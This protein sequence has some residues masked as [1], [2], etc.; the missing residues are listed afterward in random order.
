MDFLQQ[1]EQT[2]FLAWV[3]GGNSIWGY[4]TIL[5]LHT[6]GLATVAGVNAGIDLR[7]LG[8]APKIPLAPM[9][10]LFPLIWTAFAVTAVSGTILLL[11]D[12]TTKLANPV[13]YI[14]L[15]FI[16]LALVNLQLI[17]TR[18]FGDPLVDTRPVTS[19]AR[20]L[21]LTSLVLWMAATTAGR[22]M[23]YI[24]PVKGL[25]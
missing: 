14:K 2:R 16:A 11:A 22:L 7:V 24:G 4:P 17:K 21:S 10:R 6:F 9:R 20:F 25:E 18:V 3:S 12:A 15:V 13:F 23:A 19:I 5:F 8:F 1:L